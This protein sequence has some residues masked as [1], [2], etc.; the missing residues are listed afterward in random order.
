[1][2]RRQ[3]LHRALDT[4]MDAAPIILTHGGT[5][6]MRSMEKKLQANGV[7]MQRV[8]GTGKLF[9]WSRYGTVDPALTRE[10]WLHEQ[11]A[12]GWQVKP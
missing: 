11:L 1:M 12:N 8:V 4:V 3:R 10:Q 9:T 7:I 6:S 2:D 5:G